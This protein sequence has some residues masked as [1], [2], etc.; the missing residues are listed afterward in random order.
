MYYYNI[1][2]IW[3]IRVI[4][5]HVGFCFCVEKYSRSMEN[6]GVLFSFERW[7]LFNLIL[8]RVY[9]GPKIFGGEKRSYF[10]FMSN[11]WEGLQ[12]YLLLN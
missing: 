1:L 8:K 11:L 9:N 4:I 2:E 12:I 6:P 5:K 3:H 7:A 10:F